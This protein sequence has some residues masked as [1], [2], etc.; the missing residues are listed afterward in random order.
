MKK[1]KP[2][3]GDGPREEL[4]AAPVNGETGLKANEITHSSAFRRAAADA[5][6][7]AR[8]PKRLAKL[9]EDAVGKIN[10]IPRGPFADTWP[11]LMAMVRVI[12]AYARK[13]YRDVPQSNLLTII[14]AII[15]FVSPFDVI[16]DYVPILG[17][18]DDAV[19]ISLA[20]RSVRADLDAFMA[21]E[22]A[23]V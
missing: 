11:Y 3:S 12:R 9:V 5:E 4:P 18:I 8:E 23:R 16:P 13:E 2:A 15:Y 21:W 20:L 1:R 7:Y 17:H 10:V 22:T 19:V 6:A 14:A